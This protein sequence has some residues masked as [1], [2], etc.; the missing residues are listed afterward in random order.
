MTTSSEPSP[1]TL[2]NVLSVDPANADRLMD[3]LKDNTETVIKGLRGWIAT[4]L[5]VS[6][7]RRKVIIHS[8]WEALGDVEAMRADPRMVAYFPAIAE[9]ATLES[10]PGRVTVSHAR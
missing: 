2:V 3:L 5:I 10:I 1:I 9:L 8:R 7:D 4:D 6:L